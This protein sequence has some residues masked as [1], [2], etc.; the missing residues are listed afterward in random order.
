MNPWKAWF[1][2]RDQDIIRFS[3]ED[4]HFTELPK[5][6]L[7][8]IQIYEGR[9]KLQLIGYDFYFMAK[10]VNGEEFIACDIAQ[11]E[12]N[13]ESS[14]YK[15]YND[16]YVILGIWTSNAIMERVQEE[17]KKDGICTS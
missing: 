4:I 15:R 7:L 5:D 3:S 10:D 17:M 13:I 1:T 16:P 2:S 8:A 6:G 11:R 9:G 12:R 14:I